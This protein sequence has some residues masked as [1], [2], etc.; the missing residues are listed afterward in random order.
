MDGKIVILKNYRNG[1]TH[2]MLAS[3]WDRVRRMAGMNIFGI[4]DTIDVTPKVIKEVKEVK[5]VKEKDK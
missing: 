1:T 2:K 4:I 3:E 5:E